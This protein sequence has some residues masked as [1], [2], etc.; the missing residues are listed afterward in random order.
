[1]VSPLDAATHE[2]IAAQLVKLPTFWEDRMR[3]D[4]FRTYLHIFVNPNNIV[5]DV[6]EGDGV[7]AFVK[8]SIGYRLFVYGASWGRR[9]MRVPLTHRR[10][11]AAAL[12]A[13]NATVI[14]GIT[15]WDNTRA[16][17]AN[18]AAGMRLRAKIP[19][20]L[21]YNGEVVDGAWYE[22][23]RDDLGLPPVE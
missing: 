1:M 20:N 22:L 12:T 23:S 7:L 19:H 8:E 14:D 11:A 10:A 13:L 17:R 6:G 5:F 18:E 21:C 3:A 15:R 9:A 2:R 4:P 16:R